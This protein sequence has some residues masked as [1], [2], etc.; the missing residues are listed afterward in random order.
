MTSSTRDINELFDRQDMLEVMYRY[1]RSA[2]VG[3]PALMVACFTQD[4]TISLF[5]DEARLING[6]QA[7][8][9]VLAPLLGKVMAGSHYITNPE[10]TEYGSSQAV[11][12]CYMMSSQ[13]FHPDM[14]LPDRL[15][16]GRYEVRFRRDDEAWR[17]RDL[18]LFAVSEAGGDRL[19]ETDGRDWPPTFPG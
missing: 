9:D 16:W 7:L 12:H 10:F 5:A 6:P 15:R 4:C 11:L 19:R 2:D 13:R 18:R 3:D 8:Y 14:D 1:C 17:I